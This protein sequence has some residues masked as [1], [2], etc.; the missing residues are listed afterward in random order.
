MPRHQVAYRLGQHFEVV[1]IEEA[2]PWRDYWSLRSRREVV[3]Q[4]VPPDL[5][6]FTVY[7]PGRWLPELYRPRWLRDFIRRTRVR[8]AVNLLK[9]K[10]C[11]RIVLYLWRP[12]FAWALDTFDAALTCYHIDD[13]YTFTTSDQPIDAGE[14]ALL[15]RVDQVFIH[16]SGLL[17]KKGGFNP[18]TSYAP[19]GVDYSAYSTPIAEPADLAAIPHPRIGYVGVVK[20]QLDIQLLLK[21]AHRNP[22]WS[23]VLVGPRGYLGDKATLLDALGALP[24][25]YELGNRAVKDLPAYVQAM[26]VCVMPYEIN[27]YTNLIYPLKLHE[28]LATGRPTVATP[29]DSIVPFGDVVQLAKSVEE[30]QAALSASLAPVATAADVTHARR[31]RAAEHDWNLLVEQIA[32]RMRAR[33]SDLRSA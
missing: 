6:G 24:N 10:G 17:R 33:L 21:L 25:V 1:W 2:R 32:A 30:W 26:D 9:S 8:A 29:I 31:A 23:F 13:E 15:R 20:A 4:D 28:Y 5:P 3:I 12:D 16:S 14:A 22:Q 19:N 18:H 7:D 11:S 27:D